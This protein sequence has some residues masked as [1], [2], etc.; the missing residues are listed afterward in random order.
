MRIADPEK[1]PRILVAAAELF[2][3]MPFD[4]VH[5]KDIAKRAD[6]AKGTLYLHF[7][8]KESLFRAMIAEVL[9]KQLD[10]V[11]A[12]IAAESEPGERLRILVREAVRFSARYPH[13][14][15]TIHHLDGSPPREADATIRGGRERLFV[16]FEETLRG[17]RRPGTT[18]EQEIGRATLALLGMMHRVMAFTPRPWPDDLDEWIIKMFIFGFSRPYP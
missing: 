8:D 4:A 10:Q 12:R 7:S 11:E 9:G 18:P 16:L 17:L 2:A 5:M 3:E 15:E 13:Y 1:L 6:V 14:M